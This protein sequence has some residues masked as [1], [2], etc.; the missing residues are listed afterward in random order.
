MQ[1]LTIGSVT[2]ILGPDQAWMIEDLSREG[3][4]P[5]V[6]IT[7]SRETLSAT[8]AGIEASRVIAGFEQLRRGESVD[9][10]DPN[11]GR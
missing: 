10:A 7:Y 11:A 2:F 8:V 6:R 9:A 4:E 5:S 3:G 1:R